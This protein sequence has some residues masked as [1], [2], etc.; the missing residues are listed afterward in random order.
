MAKRPAN[1]EELRLLREE[2][3]LVDGAI[4]DGASYFVEE[5]DKATKS[6]APE[7]KAADDKAPKK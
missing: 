1:E 2:G 5:P 4:F 7:D 6:D 3:L